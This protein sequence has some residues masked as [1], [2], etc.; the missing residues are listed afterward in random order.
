MELTQITLGGFLIQE[1]VTLLTDLLLGGE[2][3]YL[4]TRLYP[5]S[6]PASASRMIMIFL[7]IMGIGTIEGGIVNHGWYYLFGPGW[8]TPMVLLVGSSLPFLMLGNVLS[9]KGRDVLSPKWF[10]WLYGFIAVEY[11]GWLISLC[12]WSLDEIDFKAMI[13]HL[14]IG[15]VAFVAAL[16][17]LAR[18]RDPHPAR[19]QML[20]A[21]AAILPVAVVQVLKISPARWFNM[22]DLA[23]I[24]LLLPMYLIY[25]AGK[26]FASMES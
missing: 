16:Q 4:A 14:G 26:Q 3:L 17:G 20:W 10:N 1:P 2:C 5:V 11:L 23:H 12:S 15:L 18:R 25:R 21:I 13:P 19:D 24:L 7:I 9:L 8:K 6:K 22:F